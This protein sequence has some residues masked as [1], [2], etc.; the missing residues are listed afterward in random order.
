MC[1]IKTLELIQRR[2]TKYILNDFSSSYKTRL[3]SLH[4]LPLMY[5]FE[6]LDVLFMVKCF[7]Q[8]DPSFPVLDFIPIRNSSTRSGRSTKLVHLSSKSNLSHHSYFHRIVRIWN[9]ALPPI[10]ITL[11]TATSRTNSRNSS[12]LISST[13]L[14]SDIPCTYHFICPCNRCSNLPARTI[15]HQG[16]IR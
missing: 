6:L 9:A 16:F 10:D 11:S 14:I 3:T 7:K 8:P 1:M 12:G 2:A 13:I 5:M 15:F 4:M